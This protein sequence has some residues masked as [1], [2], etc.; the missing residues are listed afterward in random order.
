MIDLLNN[1]NVSK[2]NFTRRA[3]TTGKFDTRDEWEREVRKLVDGGTRIQE[4]SEIVGSTRA[5]I[6]EYNKFRRGGY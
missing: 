4:V 5:T 3:R 6:H 2:T 1:R